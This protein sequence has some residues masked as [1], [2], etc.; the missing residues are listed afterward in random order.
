MVRKA[1]MAG[2]AIGSWPEAPADIEYYAT[3]IDGSGAQSI[4]AVSRSGK[5]G[6]FGGVLLRHGTGVVDAWVD[7]DLSRSKVN[8]LLKEAQMGG[9]FTRVDK[10]YVDAM[11][12]HAIATGIEHNAVPPEPLLQVAEVA[13]SSEWKDRRLDPKAEA[14]RL[15]QELK[16]GE[17][18]PEGISALHEHGLRWMED[19]PIIGSW[20]EDGPEIS[21]LLAGLPRSDRKGMMER[22]MT[23]ILPPERAVWGERF[24]LM[25]LWAQAS[26][27]AKYRDRTA[28]LAV[29]A[30]ALL[31]DDPLEVIPVMNLIAAQTVRA[32]LEGGW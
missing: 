32:Y 19:D 14:E 9:I 21:K 7:V 23:Q 3:M 30:Y 10:G 12:Q 31:E 25:A 24:L 26:A 22:V 15:F 29:V 8:R 11:I 20:F 17:L 18:P 16:L 6:L 13:G 2:V 1:R 4:L 27:E 5:K 28:D